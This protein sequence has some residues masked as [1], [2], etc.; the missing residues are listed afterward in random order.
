MKKLR[1]PLLWLWMLSKRLF[2]K[3]V[4]LILLVLIPVLVL[5]YS[6]TA[7]EDSG[8]MTVLLYCEEPDEL[9][10]NLFEDL[11]SS[12]QLL[13]V[14]VAESAEEACTLVQTGK[15]DA[16][17]IFPAE[18][19]EHIT[20]FAEDPNG[21]GGFI[22]VVEQQDNIGLT[23]TREKLTGAV[24]A[25][26]AKLVYLNYLHSLAPL[27]EELTDEEMLEYYEQAN[28][29][30]RLF[31]FQSDEDRE[32]TVG[33]YLLT[34][35]RGLLATVVVI[36]ALAASMYY[37]RDRKNGT[38]AWVPA[39]KQILPEL[40]SH[41]TAVFF[42]TLTALCALLL[43]GL[44]GPIMTELATLLVYSFCVC[45]FVMVL[46]RLCV[47]VRVLGIAMPLLV[48]VMFVVCPVFVDLA[49]FRHVQ[50][51]LPPTYY[52]NAIANPAYLLYGLGYI[53]ICAGFCLVWDKLTSK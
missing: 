38:F 22:R 4:F 49:V 26:T 39:S 8:V 18:L 13:Q 10:D 50:L 6:T 24:Y 16:A 29:S 35:L 25:E 46:R 17:W 51:A 3:P 19:Q 2:Q 12:S 31:D 30:S 14:R 32:E 27:L 7:R 1:K 41:F 43:C 9:T 52:V 42:V 44:A 34:P 45:G 20:R 33:N 53:L 11:L 37:I 21:A 40:A 48:V 47:S 28:M 23:M 36:V 5:G 15:V